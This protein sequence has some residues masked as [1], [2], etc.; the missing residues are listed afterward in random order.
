MQHPIRTGTAYF[1]CHH[2]KHVRS[3]FAE[4]AQTCDWL[5]LPMS[6]ADLR[7]SPGTV[8]EI[9]AA[10]HDA[11]IEV[12]IDPW[13][14]GGIFGGEALSGF[15]GEYPDECQ[16]SD[17]G[18]H[19]PSAC[20]NSPVFR[21]FL[22]GWIDVAAQSGA[23]VLFWD[24]PHFW[25]GAWHGTPERWACF[26][27]YC[28]RAYAE[29]TGQELSQ[30]SRAA[31]E[32]WQADVLRQLLNELTTAG[33]AHGMRNAV[34]LISA[35]EQFA[36][37]EP[38]AALPHV[39]NLGTDPYWFLDHQHDRHDFVRTWTERLLQVT[40]A[41]G[42][43]HHVWFQGFKVPAGGAVQ[44]GEMIDLVQELDVRNFAVWG[45]GACAHMSSLACADSDEVWDTVTTRFRRL[46]AGA[47]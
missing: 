16:V 10:A 13:G 42:K 25:L 15:V 27:A 2:I 26:C 47:T 43:P 31:V 33:H 21:E 3:D 9:T 14:V 23:D 46:K 35:E 24:E 32:R 5:V 18:K 8:R 40:A 19:L 45:F 4:L 28:Q 39:D 37:W 20:P 11:G 41:A 22:H 17:Q 36:A 30:S 38:I 29:A 1:G 12:W 44:V 6:E 7:W 34:C